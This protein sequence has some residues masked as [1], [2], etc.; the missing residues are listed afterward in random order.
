MGSMARRAHFGLDLEMNLAG[1]HNALNATAAAALAA[2]QGI[3]AD[4][5]QQALGEF[6]K[7]EAP[8]GSAS[9]NRR[10]HHH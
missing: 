9:P 4:A 7:R 5:I 1:E 10:H 8:T 6:Q 3:G 2:G